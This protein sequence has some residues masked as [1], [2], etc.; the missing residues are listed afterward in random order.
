MSA[1]LKVYSRSGNRLRLVEELGG[2]QVREP[3]AQRLLGS[4]AIACS[5]ANGTSL[6]ITAAACSRR[7]SSGGSRSMRAARI[8]CT[9]AGTWMRLHGPRQPIGAALAGQRAGLHQRPHA[10]FQE[11]RVA[12]GALDQQLR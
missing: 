4:S 7:L 11:E 3:A 12:L 1:C 2:L 6:P 8:A 10:L 5:S 9:V